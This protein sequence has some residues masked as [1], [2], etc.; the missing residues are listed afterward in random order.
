MTIA[1]QNILAEGERQL[2]PGIGVGRLDA[3]PG[4]RRGTRVAP[5]TAG[6]M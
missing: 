6:E 3:L 4:E 2:S 5:I 1:A